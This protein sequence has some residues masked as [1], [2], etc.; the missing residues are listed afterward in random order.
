[1]TL[2]PTTSVLISA[3]Y[4][5]NRVQ[6]RSP[7]HKYLFDLKVMMNAYMLYPGAR[8][9]LTLH[10]REEVGDDLVMSWAGIREGEM[11]WGVNISVS[12]VLSFKKWWM[13]AP[14]HAMNIC[15]VLIKVVPSCLVHQASSHKSNP[16]LLAR[17]V[18]E[19]DLFK[20]VMYSGVSSYAGHSKN[21]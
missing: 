17:F 13:K 3:F 1:M 14:S 20:H 11:G 19:V 8:L 6:N 16:T 12:K 15:D 10:D 9:R 21:I 18:T 5:T 7:T 4:T 2:H